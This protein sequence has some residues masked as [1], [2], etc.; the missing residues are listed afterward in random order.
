[1]IDLE[2]WKTYQS[3]KDPHTTDRI[4]IEM[5]HGTFLPGM[6]NII[7][8]G[9]GLVNL[10]VEAKQSGRYDGSDSGSGSSDSSG[11]SSSSES[12]YGSSYSDS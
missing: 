4:Y 11:S 2:L 12:S 7:D 8:Y 5:C 9:K 10:D 3:L 6:K 1:M